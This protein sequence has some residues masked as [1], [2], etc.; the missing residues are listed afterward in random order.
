MLCKLLPDDYQST[1]EKLKSLPEFLGPEQ[2]Q[3]LDSLMPTTSMDVKIINEKII[4]FIVVTLSYNSSSGGMTRFSDIMDQ[5][6]GSSSCEQEI[7]CGMVVRILKKLPI[8][9]NTVVQSM[10]TNHIGI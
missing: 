8:K 2:Q 7:R 3:L 9:Y 4:T 10:F 6:V 1:I 5:L